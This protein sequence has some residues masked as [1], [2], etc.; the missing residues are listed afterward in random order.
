MK[1]FATLSVGCLCMI[2]LSWAVARAA[3]EKSAEKGPVIQASEAKDN[4]GKEVVVE[5]VVV[6]GRMLE[7]KGICFLN[8]S[9]DQNDPDGFTAFITKSRPEQI[10]GR[11]QDRR[12][13]RSLQPEENPSQRQSEEIQRQGGNRGQFPQPNQ[14]C[15]RGRRTG[16][17]RRPRIRK[18]DVT[19]FSA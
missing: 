6:G 11:S 5:F 19:G 7:D 12:S 9:T 4:V 15:R 18:K 2:A 13:V 3:D 8:S 14:D 10:Q 17:N 1:R 16:R